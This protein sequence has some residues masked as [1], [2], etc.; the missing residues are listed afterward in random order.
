M[1]NDW[2]SNRIKRL[3]VLEAPEVLHDDDN[4][5]LPGWYFED[6]NGDLHGPF[7][8]YEMAHEALIHYAEELE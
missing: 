1:S 4:P 6:D 2:R 7:E 3:I 5:M 8:S